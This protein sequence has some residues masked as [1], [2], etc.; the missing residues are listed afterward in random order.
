MKAFRIRKLANA[1]FPSGEV[2]S[3]LVG[4]VVHGEKFVERRLGGLWVG[5][6]VELLQLG[7]E[8]RANAMNEAVHSGQTTIRIPK[9]A[10]RKLRRE[11]GFFTDIVVVE[12]D[13]GEF[14]FR[15]FGA[16]GVVANYQ[17]AVAALT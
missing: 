5:G 9:K 12:H 8:F 15:C 16:K 2:T 11:S 10:I 6:A 3:N 14:R 17:V 1:F 4:A 13:K 7:I